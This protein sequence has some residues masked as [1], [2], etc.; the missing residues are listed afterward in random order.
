MR[1]S[2]CALDSGLRGPVSRPGLVSVLWPWA[3]YFT[4]TVP[5]PPRH[6]YEYWKIFRGAWWNTGGNFFDGMASHSEGSSYTLSCHME[7]GIGSSCQ[8]KWLKY[9]LFTFTI[10]ILASQQYVLPSSEV[11]TFLQCFNFVGVHWNTRVSNMMNFWVLNFRVNW[12]MESLW[13]FS[14]I[15]QS[16]AP[17]YFL[18]WWSVFLLA[19]TLLLLLQVR[20]DGI[21]SFTYMN[22]VL[23]C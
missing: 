11:F 5:L 1:H 7:T 23:S 10:Q 6:M 8:D 3:K 15:Q 21:A 12:D 9:R 2:S 17:V 13:S 22:A 20:T 14:A 18:E 19:R 4:F 16:W